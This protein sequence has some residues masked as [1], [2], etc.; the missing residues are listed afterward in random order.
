[1]SNILTFPTGGR[2]PEN[3]RE[4]HNPSF[5]SGDEPARW[6]SP[7]YK[8]SGRPNM[9]TFV[10]RSYDLI[11]KSSEADLVRDVRQDPHKANT[12]LRKIREQLRQNREHA[13]ARE[14]LLDAAEAKLSAAIAAVQ[15]DRSVE[16]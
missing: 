14:N 1:M 9:H 13:I 2:P 6:R 5:I 12:K 11:I 16:G 10:F 8:S 7:G 3:V 4:F 15:S